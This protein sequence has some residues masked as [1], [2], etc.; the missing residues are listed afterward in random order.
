M[1]TYSLIFYLIPHC[2]GFIQ[3]EAPRVTSTHL[4][5]HQHDRFFRQ[6]LDAIQWLQAIRPDLSLRLVLKASSFLSCSHQPCWKFAWARLFSLTFMFFLRKLPLHGSCSIEGFHW[7]HIQYPKSN[8]SVSLG[9]TERWLS[10]LSD[11]LRPK[12]LEEPGYL[13]R[14]VPPGGLWAQPL[15]C[16]LEEDGYPPILPQGQW[17]FTFLFTTE[18]TSAWNF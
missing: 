13:T 17:F 15:N 12:R 1:G 16:F 10:W 8:A 6:S 2:F 4:Q 9:G 14:T 18:S 11:K 7:K 3:Q 5:G